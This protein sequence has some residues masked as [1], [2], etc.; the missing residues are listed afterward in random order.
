MENSLGGM[1]VN[2]KKIIFS[3]ILFIVGFTATYLF[4][5]YHTGLRLKLVA[6]PMEF[7]IKSIKFAAV[8]KT[9][10]SCIIGAILS[11]LPHIIKKK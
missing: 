1:L 9:I 4:M 2:C 8:F 10:M 7:F 6:E 5:C 11:I 3:V